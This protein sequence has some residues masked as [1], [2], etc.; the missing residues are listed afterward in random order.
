[1]LL[2]YGEYEAAI[3]IDGELFEPLKDENILKN[4]YR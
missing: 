4:V 1:M 2:Y 3:G